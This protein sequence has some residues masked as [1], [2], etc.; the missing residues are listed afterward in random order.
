MTQVTLAHALPDDPI[1]WWIYLGTFVVYAVARWFFAWR[2]ARRDGDGHPARA[3][4]AEDDPQPD[5]SGGFRSYRQ[6]FGFVGSAVAVLA[7]A[8]VTAGR[9]RVVLLWV[10]IPLLVT[11]LSYLDFRQSR[12]ARARS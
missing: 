10:I 6:F 1:G 9:L 11:A 3:A 5:V 12:A 7:V 2:Q 4:L 8:A